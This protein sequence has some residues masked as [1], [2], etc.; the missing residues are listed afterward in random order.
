[1][2]RSSHRSPCITA[3]WSKRWGDGILAEFHGVVDALRCVVDNQQEKAKRNSLEKGDPD[4]L[5]SKLS[6]S[7]APN[8]DATTMSMSLSFRSVGSQRTID[9]KGERFGL[10]VNLDIDLGS[11]FH[12]AAC[13]DLKVFRGIA[14]RVR[15]SDKQPV[16]PIGHFGAGCRF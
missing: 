6:D 8:I 1:M 14:G 12:N 3:D 4:G 11:D 7:F 15:Q 5:R 2:I 9:A 13:R 10:S 16:L